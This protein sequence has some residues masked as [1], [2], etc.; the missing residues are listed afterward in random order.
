MTD[1]DLNSSQ[2]RM[3]RSSVASVKSPLA[4]NQ[5]D[6]S[7]KDEANEEFDVQDEKIRLKFGDSS[8]WFPDQRKESNRVRTTKYTWLT[9]A[10]LSLL[11]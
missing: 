1:S 9:W 10:P 3:K 11:F 5:T 2:E 7:E 6:P 8:M 4:Q